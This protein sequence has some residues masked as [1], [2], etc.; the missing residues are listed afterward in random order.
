MSG[1]YLSLQV[2]SLPNEAEAEF[3]SRLSEF[4]TAMLR[5]HPD[6]FEKVYAETVKFTAEADRLTRQ[7]LL[8]ANI[9]DLLEQ[10][11]QAAGIEFSPIDRDDIYT[12]YEAAPP[13][14]MW[15]EH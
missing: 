4:W 14:W 13:D 6:D 12:K 10:E 1:D 3:K 7:Y 11:L 8:E 9:A 2:R 5:H 15:I